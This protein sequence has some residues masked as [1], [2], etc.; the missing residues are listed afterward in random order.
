M[1][2]TADAVI[3][4]GGV[5]GASIAYHLARRQFGR[6]VLLEK[7]SLA[8]GSTGRSVATIDTI[9][10]HKPSVELYARSAA[11]FQNCQALLEADCGYVKTGSI[12]LGGQQHEESFQSAKHFMNGKGLQIRSMPLEEIK[13]LEPQIVLEGITTAIHAP[14]AGYA[15]P[16]LTTTNMAAA[17][18]QLGAKIDQGRRVKKINF[19]GGKVVG[20]ETTDAPIATPIIILAAGP[21]N[22]ELL[23]KLKIKLPLQIVR[24]PVI[25]LRRPLAFGPAPTA[26]L[27]MT[28]GIYA[29]PESGG[30]TLLGSLDPLVG[31][32][33]IDRPEEGVGYISDSYIS[34]AMERLIR[35]Y[36]I[37]DHAQLL[38]GWAG[39]MT[40]S[41]DWQPIIGQ[42]SE[43]QGLY[44][45]AGLSGLGFQI[46]PAIGELISGSIVGDAEA[47]GILAPFSAERFQSGRHHATY[48]STLST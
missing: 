43:L 21:W 34:W 24:H 20:L 22:K 1:G 46:S 14:H 10:L 2:E 23:N 47:K 15:D 32:E 29:R 12:L 38:K 6:I 48:R 30:L 45:I 3:V 25:A 13:R 4:G 9:T 5:I 28:L 36:P 17:A 8:S 27:D 37:F 26:M 40:L 44:Y 31:H 35:R 33:A 41:P 7:E 39:L 16:Y 18:K 42:Q 19:S 11:F